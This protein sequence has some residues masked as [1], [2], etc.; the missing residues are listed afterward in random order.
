MKKL[1]GAALLGLLVLA[2]AS[3]QAAYDSN[4]VKDAMH[5]NGGSLQAAKKAIDAADPK[6][7]ADAFLAIVTANKPLLSMDPP[8]GTK[9]DWDKA[10]NGL[11]ATAQKGAAAA[12]AKD[13]DGAKA[14]LADLRKAMGA[15][16]GA[17]RG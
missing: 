3:A 9:A 4:K 16:H 13:W 15:G 8:K 1:F 2:G 14:A 6:G 12:Q 5:V 10:F 7:A 11:I 17:F